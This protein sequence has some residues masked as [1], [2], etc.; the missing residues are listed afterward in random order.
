MK[1]WVAATC[2][3]GVSLTASAAGPSPAPRSAETHPTAHAV[4][5]PALPQRFF[6]ERIDDVLG[7]VWA[8]RGHGR[9]VFV[10]AREAR[11]VQRSGTKGFATAME[12][13]GAREDARIEP[14]EVDAARLN[15]ISGRRAS[16]R[17][18]LRMA[19][20]LETQDAWPGVDVRWETGR[21]E[22]KYAF[23]VEPGADPGEVRL[24]W[25]GAGSVRVAPSG[26]LVVATPLGE[27]RDARPTAWTESDAGRV[28]VDVRWTV[29]ATATATF[30][31]GAHDPDA[32]LVIDP[33]IVVSSGFLGGVGDEDVPH[34]VATDATGAAYVGGQ[35][36]GTDFPT[37]PGAFDTVSDGNG[38]DGFIAKVK[39]DGTGFV[40]VT[41]IGGGFYDS[42]AGVAL[43][44]QNRVVFGGSTS[45]DET[46]FPVLGGPDL[47]YNGGSDGFVGRLAA[48]GSTLDWC[49][50]FGGDQF[51]TPRAV[52]VDA[53]D[54]VYLCGET[55]STEATFPVLVGPDLTYNGQFTDAFVAKVK[56]DGSGLVYCGY[57]G[58][59][60]R[61]Y[62]YG[63]A[64][65]PG[66]V[67]VVVGRT[68]ADETTFPVV[69]GPDL[70]FNGGDDGYVARV[71][72][73]G[74]ALD[75]CGYV[76]G[77]QND[78]LYDAA[79]DASGNV[80][81]CGY[82]YSSQATFPV[83][84]G[85][86]LTWAGQEDG[87]IAK[88]TPAG[89]ITY[90]GYIGGVENNEEATNVEVD[91]QGR[92]IVV[93]Y[94]TSDEQLGG[95]PAL[96][97][98]DLTYNG[99]NDAFAATVKADGSGFDSLGYVG[100]DDNDY[101]TAVAISSSGAIWMVGQTSSTQATFPTLGGPDLTENGGTDVFITRL[102][103]SA[104][105]SLGVT[106]SF[107]APKK[108]KA[109]INTSTPAKS[110][111]TAAGNLDVGTNDLDPSGTTRVTIGGTTYSF[112]G[113]GLDATGK[114]FRLT[115]P[116]IDLRVRFSKRG[117]SASAFR[118]TLRRDLAGIVDPE[119]PLT[120]R[121][122]NGGVDAA[123]LFSLT[124]G[125]YRG[126]KPRGA[127]ASPALYPTLA[128]ARVKGAGKDTLALRGGFATDGTTPATA[129]EVEVS[130]GT[131]LHQTISAE[132][133]V[134]SGDRWTYKGA[135]GGITQLT[136]DYAKQSITLKA[137]K[138]DLGAFDADRNPVE[139]RVRIGADSRAVRVLVGRRGVA[140][141]Y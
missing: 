42:V 13:V 107:I 71:K 122:E 66:G 16:W 79:V 110:R 102:A 93:G 6:E 123:A 117:G 68:S 26:E 97:G 74:T 22:V 11:V 4:S 46:T 49:G 52:G 36:E 41:L 69:G 104:L 119:G 17:T 98:P 88:I 96:A 65:T 61:D 21:A 70:T 62:G 82:A 51:E 83:T 73:D 55:K 47:T 34:G 128:L 141:G 115:N 56:A 89:A 76:G 3:I 53:A 20:T 126:S 138:A 137:K 121:F 130:F 9:T 95:F 25:R 2:L 81:V 38:A 35:T 44:S 140:V 139:L 72:A 100:G 125:A 108:V 85:P 80:Y 92:A 64:V 67:A 63:M 59:N 14:S 87:V 18:G 112:D 24:R 39:P 12:L 109:R 120:M 99:K 43:D 10:A 77:A 29:D 15:R 8:V 48:D 57:I 91:A 33:S 133:F 127:L 101:A 40:W 7:P 136:I 78:A 106:D 134:R 58:G 114:R 86:D 131:V 60:A 75:L 54:A 5:R 105:P 50:F 94:T 116:D 45:S 31:L 124:K 23:V 19:R 1:R 113:L 28:P 111:L 32:T 103:D 132:S 37:T 129:S 27:I 84:V 90:C 30:V 118:L 135:P